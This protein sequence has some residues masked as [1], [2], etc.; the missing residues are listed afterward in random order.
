M[1]LPLNQWI[2][3]VRPHL[4]G[5]EAACDVIQWHVRDLPLRPDFLTAAEVDMRNAERAL[6]KA[7]KAVRRARRIYMAK[8]VER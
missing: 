8:E 7:S 4:D 2:A 5:I 3:E 1:R 6:L